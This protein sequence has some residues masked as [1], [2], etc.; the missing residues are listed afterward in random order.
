VPNSV[1]PAP[2]AA[3]DGVRWRYRALL[4]R[5]PAA[6][7]LLPPSLRSYVAGETAAA[8]DGVPEQAHD[9]GADSAGAAAPAHGQ[10]T[11]D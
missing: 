5:W 6:M 9:L 10:S 8:D 3:P 2:E 7:E 1:A 4:R 11:A